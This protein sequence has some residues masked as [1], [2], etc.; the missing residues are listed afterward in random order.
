MITKHNNKIINNNNKIINVILIIRCNNNYKHRKNIE[1]NNININ[2]KYN[3]KKSKRI[4][5]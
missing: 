5:T 3:V 1:N 2:I 4:N